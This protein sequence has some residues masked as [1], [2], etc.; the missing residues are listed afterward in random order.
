[1]PHQ[2]SRYRRRDRLWKDQQGLCC[3]C[4]KGMMHWNDLRGDPI[5]AKAF[6]VRT[7]GR[8]ERIAR[9]PPRLATIEHLRD[10]YH[11][12]RRDGN[13]N[14]EK[15]WALA[16][17]ECNTERGNARTREQPIEELRKRASGS[18]RDG[19]AEASQAPEASPVKDEDAERRQIQDQPPPTSGPDWQQSALG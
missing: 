14:R 7:T 18:R 19:Y 5:K 10:R 11:P 15:R 3:Y 8:Q 4:G 12:G 16:C 13:P 9:M 1:M 6:G 2:R 17:W